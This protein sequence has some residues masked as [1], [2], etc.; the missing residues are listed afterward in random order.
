MLAATLWGPSPSGADAQARSAL[1]PAMRLQAMPFAYQTFNNCGPQAIASVLGYYGQ[2]V[3]QQ[4]VAA[5]AKATPTGYMTADAIGRYVTRYGLEARRF[6]GGRRTHL[7]ALVALG[8][9]VIVLQWL[10]PRSTIP[11]FRVVT[12]F[13]DG[14]QTFRVLDPLYGPQIAIPYTLFDQLWTVNHAEFIPVYPPKTAP[15][16]RSALGL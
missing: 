4:Q 1:P 16:V 8:V 10:G 14:Q 11:H 3:S 6:V 9:P 5:V 12:G 7:R 15:A 13:D 2:Q